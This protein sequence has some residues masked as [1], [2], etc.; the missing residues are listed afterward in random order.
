MPNGVQGQPK[1]LETDC[2]KDLVGEKVLGILDGKE[3]LE[4][5]MDFLFSLL[6]FPFKLIIEIEPFYV[7]AS[8]HNAVYLY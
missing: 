3:V 1:S 5:P 2:L 7:S 8:G 4:F 6:Y